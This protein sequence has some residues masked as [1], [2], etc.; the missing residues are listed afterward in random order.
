VS[1]SD[2]WAHIDPHATLDFSLAEDPF[3]LPEPARKLRDQ[4]L[5]NFRWFERT[6]QRLDEVKGL[7]VPLKWWPANRMQPQAGI[8]DNLVD[9]TT[10]AVH[11]MDQMLFFKPWWMWEKEAEIEARKAD[12]RGDLTD[13]DGEVLDDDTGIRLQASKRRPG[14][15]RDRKDHRP[16]VTGSDIQYEGEEERTGGRY[17]SV[18]DSD[19]VVNE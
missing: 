2:E 17:E 3:K 18:M 19:L 12:T 14:D 4:K 11:R 16:E 7:P 15:P 5:F 8:F 6:P 1:E 10:G 9:G 13:K